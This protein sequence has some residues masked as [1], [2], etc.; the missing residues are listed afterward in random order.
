MEMAK[1]DVPGVWTYNYYDGWVPNYMFW[2]GVTHNSIG[3]FYETQSFRGQNYADGRAEPEP[4]VV[5]AQPDAERHHVGAARQREHAA[6]RAP[7]L[8]EQRREEQGDVPRELLPEE[9][10]HDRARPDQGAVRLRRP[11]GAAA[12]RRG[13]GADEP[14]PPRRGRSPHRQRRVHRRQRRRSPPATTSSASISRTARSSRRCSACSSIAP[15]NPRPYDDTG[16][17]IPLVRNVKATAIADKAILQQP[18]TLATAD[19]KIAGHHHR[20]RAGA[21][22]RSHDRQH[23]GDVPLPARRRE[24][25]GGGAGVRGR[26]PQVR[27]RARS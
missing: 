13:G 15:E 3:R 27:A 7:D 8:D 9:Q 1:R 11:G 21:H 19:F 17:A 4:R 2:I 12:P 16:W 23:A 26:R 5:P 22:R 10:A 14:D 6:E 25:V 20:H 18:M 24:D